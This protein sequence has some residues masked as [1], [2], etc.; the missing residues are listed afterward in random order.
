MKA[1]KLVS[2]GTIELQEVPI[3]EID[4]DEVLIKVAGAGRANLICIYSKWANR[5]RSS[6]A[7]WATRPL[8]TWTVW[9]RT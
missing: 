2:P 6:A 1:L 3:P 7:R 4:A 5:G 9:G 8:A